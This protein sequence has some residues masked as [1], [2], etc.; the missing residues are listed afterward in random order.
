[1]DAQ[2]TKVPMCKILNPNQETIV[3]IDGEIFER[4]ITLG[5][6]TK[7]K[8]KIELQNS[9]VPEQVL[10]SLKCFIIEPTFPF[11]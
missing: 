7:L 2:T 8:Q 11:P 6:I 5:R 1:M 4:V 10:I 9:F 3:S